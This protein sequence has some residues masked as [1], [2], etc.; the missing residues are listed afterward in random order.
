[1]NILKNTTKDN[2]G[3][4]IDLTLEPFR[5]GNFACVALLNVGIFIP[6][7]EE[8]GIFFSG[9]RLQVIYRVSFSTGTPLKLL[10]VRLHS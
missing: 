2:Y 1:M 5:G 7:G 8:P 9:S 3:L 6:N 10:S 4:I